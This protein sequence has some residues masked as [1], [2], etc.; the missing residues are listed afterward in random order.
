VGSSERSRVNGWERVSLITRSKKGTQRITRKGGGDAHRIQEA[1]VLVQ[2]HILCSAHSS[3]WL[4]SVPVQRL[5]SFM[6]SECSESLIVYADLEN[7]IFFLALK[8]WAKVWEPW[9]VCANQGEIAGKIVWE[10]QRKRCRRIFLQLSQ[11]LTDIDEHTP[12]H[13]SPARYD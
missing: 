4:F 10:M 1:K 2:N 11:K 5:C 8:L 3:F 9:C 12:L 6:L 7:C 13:T